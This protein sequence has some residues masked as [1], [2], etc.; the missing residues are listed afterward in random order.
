[1]QCSNIWNHSGFHVQLLVKKYTL[2]SSL[3]STSLCSVPSSGVQPYYQNRINFVVLS[4]QTFFVIKHLGAWAQ[5]A[6]ALQDVGWL[7]WGCSPW[8]SQG[9]MVQKSLWR[10]QHPEMWISTQSMYHFFAWVW[11]EKQKQSQPNDTVRSPFQTELLFSGNTYIYIHTYIRKQ[12]STERFCRALW[13]IT[14][15]KNPSAKPWWLKERF[16]HMPTTPWP[17]L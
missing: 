1:M 4:T 12:F 11:R 5:D 3:Q 16:L 6:A 15:K 14:S 2:I 9:A 13:G 7:W 17:H 10:P 8:E